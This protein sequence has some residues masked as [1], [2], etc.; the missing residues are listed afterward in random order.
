MKY[1]IS[2]S[3]SFGHRSA[4]PAVNQYASAD[5]D[6]ETFARVMNKITAQDAEIVAQKKINY[7][8]ENKNCELENKNNEL[9][10]RIKRLEHLIIK[11]SKE[12]DNK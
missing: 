3:F 7:K 4:R 5:V 12:L 8:L 1:Y 2:E 9:E 10:T 11:M 6:S